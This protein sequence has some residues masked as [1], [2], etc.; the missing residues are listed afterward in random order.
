[1][2]TVIVVIHVIVALLL[3][4]VV[5]LQSGKAGGLGNIFGGGSEQLFST[6]SGTAFMRK[7]TIALALFFVITSITLTFLTY[8]MTLRTVTGIVPTAPAEAPPEP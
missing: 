2:Y 7:T 4:L 6:P 8:R 3:I 1:M 5:L